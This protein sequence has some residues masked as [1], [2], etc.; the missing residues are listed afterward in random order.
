MAPRTTTAF[1]GARVPRL[2]VHPARSGDVIRGAFIFDAYDRDVIAWRAVLN[3]GISGSDVRDMM[4][5]A[6]ERRFGTFRAPEAVE[7]PSDTGAPSAVRKTR[8]FDRQRGLKP[9]FTREQ[10]PQSNGPSEA[11]AR[12]AIACRRNRLRINRRVDWGSQ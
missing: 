4:L 8:N 9:C 1:T 11:L 12:L 7:I 2:R 3:A 6:V 5:E 10:S